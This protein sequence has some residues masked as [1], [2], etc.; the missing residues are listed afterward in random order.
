MPASYAHLSFGRKILHTLP[1]GRLRQIIEGG[2]ALFE[3]GLLGPDIL[4]FYHPLGHNPVNRIGHELHDRSGTSFLAR[5][6]CRTADNGQLA[7]LLGFICHYALDSECH[8][9][10]EYYIEKL[11]RYHSSIETDLERTLMIRDGLDPFHFS[12][13][14]CVRNTAANAA[15]IAPF[16]GVSPKEIRTALTSMKRIGRLLVPS[17]RTKHSLLT[18]AGSVIGEGSIVSQLTMDRTPDPAY[19]N[20]NRDIAQRMEQ[21]IPVAIALMNNFLAW[22]RGERPLSQRF[23]PTFSFDTEELARLKE[24]DMCV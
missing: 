18:W 16:Y 20:S 15:S 4:F 24:R 17:S 19:D 3:I 1:S 2:T 13:A 8:T 12:A 11:G 5:E 10:V 7:Y 23:E 9:L 22:H 6:V 14:A 21:S